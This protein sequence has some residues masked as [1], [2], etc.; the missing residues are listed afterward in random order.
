MQKLYLITSINNAERYTIVHV[1]GLYNDINLAK[2][3]LPLI[4]KRLGWD[5]EPTVKRET[6]WI[7]YWGD[8]SD[9]LEGPKENNENGMVGYILKIEEKNL[10]EDW[11]FE[12]TKRGIV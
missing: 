11:H 5:G 4:W 10:N 9:S 1:H 7:Q 6:E 12:D 2:S 3:N 8:G